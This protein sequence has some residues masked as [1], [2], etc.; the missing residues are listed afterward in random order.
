MALGETDYGLNGLVGG[1]V[2]FIAFF[3]GILSSANARFY[4]YSIGSAKMAKD[5]DAALEDCRKWF[6]TALSVH[7]VVPFL[8]I[9]IGYPIGV[10]AIRYWLT[11]P[12]ERICDCVWVFR[13]S[14]VSC[15]VCMVN[16]PFAAMYTAKQYI[17]ELTIY[18]FI[19]STLN[20]CFVYYMVSHP[21]VW[22]VGF[23]AWTCL[24]SIAP[25]V[26][27]CIRACWIFPECK[28]KISYMWNLDKLKK[29]GSY[30][31]WVLGGAL[32]TLLRT[33]GISIL[34]NKFFGASMN[35]AQAIGN[36]L[37]GH[38]TTLAS[39]M[40][41]AFTPVITQACGAGD[42]NRMNVYVIRTCKFN[43]VLS[44][45]FAIPL[46][47]ELDE[48]VHLW[49]KVPPAHVVGLC[50]CAMVLYFVDSCTTGQMVVVNAT[51]RIALYHIVMSAINVFTLPL[52]IVCAVIWKNVYFIMGSVVFMQILNSIG[53]VVFARLLAGTSVLL[54]CK[55]VVIP[56]AV[57][58]V[59][60]GAVGYSVRLV[61]DASF[62]RV[63]VTTIMFELTFFPLVW[64]FALNDEER[65]YVYN[66]G[67]LKFNKIFRVAEK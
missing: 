52:A 25:Q 41:G 3:N 55:E 22:L 5:K 24:L 28:M 16:V 43:M 6:N 46:A 61:L 44:M 62:M 12:P 17:A 48:V 21:D 38:C 32:C 37:Q 4:A 50:Y 54:W 53:R 59:V 15:F 11:I 34:I 29:L 51:G 42:F 35:A 13:F 60:C 65:T 8:L 14:C 45:I 39:A 19:T 63:C 9:V 20:V 40:Q 1:L 66:R 49:L 47:L 27:I 64:F 57:L 10:H 36:C 67:L 30:S 33:N 58:V 2:V 18:G 26:F 31:G 23:A 56:S 7:S